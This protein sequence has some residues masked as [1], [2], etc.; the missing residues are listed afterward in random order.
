[1]G[2]KLTMDWEWTKQSLKRPRLAL[3]LQNAAREHRSM[4]R[5]FRLR[6]EAVSSPGIKLQFPHLSLSFSQYFARNF[7]SILMLSI[8]DH[9]GIPT[10]RLRTYALVTHAIRGIVTASDNI[11]DNEDKGALTIVNMDGRVLSN[12]LL[13]LVQHDLVHEVI[14]EV[15]PNVSVRRKAHSLLMNSLAAIAQEESTEENAVEEVLHPDE[16]LQA[17]H[18]YRGGRLLELA[19]VLPEII[20]RELAPAIS[21]LKAGIYRIGL[22]VQSLDDVTDFAV[23][24][25]SRNHNLLRSWIVHK[26]SDGPMTDKDLVHIPQ[27]ELSQPERRF[28]NATKDIVRFAIDLALEGFDRLQKH[29]YPIDHASAL[30]LVHV[31]FRLRG[32]RKLWELYVCEEA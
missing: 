11:L 5:E 16:L 4:E 7:F 17:I 12:I 23:D 28:P 2:Q 22:A 3:L 6:L 26:R 18:H 30:E 29:G 14:L 24:L 21:E 19:F 31:L 15:A 13:I 8:L 1:M 10:P 9:L 20:E 25:R 27:D 32:V